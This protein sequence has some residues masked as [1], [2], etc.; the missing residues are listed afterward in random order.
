MAG[1]YLDSD[2]EDALVRDLQVRVA[3]LERKLPPPDDDDD[4]QFIVARAEITLA[5]TGSINAVAS[6]DWS[7]FCDF[8][9]KPFAAFSPE[10]ATSPFTTFLPQIDDSAWDVSSGRYVGVDVQVVTANSGLGTV[11][12][13]FFGIGHVF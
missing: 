5:T 8:A 4:D 1:R 13:A 7:G 12:C 2:A 3:R 10:Y 11:H 6:L 9:A